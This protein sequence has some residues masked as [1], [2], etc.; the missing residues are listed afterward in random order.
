MSRTSRYDLS[1]ISQDQNGVTDVNDELSGIPHDPGLGKDALSRGP[2]NDEKPS[3]GLQT[4]ARV[5]RRR[6]AS[7]RNRRC[8][9]KL[10]LTFVC[11]NYISLHLHIS[12]NHFADLLEP[13]SYF[14]GKKQD[15]IRQN[16]KK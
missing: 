2:T 4:T 5:E 10:I 7:N 6:R 13:L 11:K 14:K 3:E 1:T 9:H 8:A 12:K 16:D 15:G